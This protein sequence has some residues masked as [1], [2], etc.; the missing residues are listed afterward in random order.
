MAGTSFSGKVAMKRSSFVLFALLLLVFAMPAGAADRPLSEKTGREILQELR[1]IR[2]LLEKQQQPARPQPAPARPEQP[3]TATVSAAGGHALG[4]SD[5]PLTVVEYTDYQCPF[6]KRFHDTTFP[7]LKKNFIDTG[8][9]RFISRN[10]P[11]P[12][13]QFA[14]QAAQ[15][16]V[17]AGEQGKY[18]EMRDL[19]FKNQHKLD[20]ESLVGY[21]RDLSL[22]ADEFAGCL[23][24]GKRRKEIEDEAASARSAGI[25]GTPSFV[26]GR[27]K[28]K[29][30]EG[31][32][33][34]GAQPYAAFA[35]QI[36][37]LLQNGALRNR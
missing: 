33:I 23:D 2:Q 15:A 14:L 4:R 36:N 22:K 30:V 12:F 10:L 17:C 7:E 35:G 19:L 29:S 21:A 25:S 5:A 3:Q 26:L 37:G 34:V 6:C 18:W 9:V 28:G 31:R 11:L 24:D 20:R 8:K 32:K 27:E 1:Q 16:A 13:H